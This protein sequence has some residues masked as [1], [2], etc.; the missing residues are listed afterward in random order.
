MRIAVQNPTMPRVNIYLPSDI[1]ELAE[2]WRG[3]RS[4]SEICARAIKDEFD[5][6]EMHRAPPAL[7]KTLRRPSPLEDELIKKFRCV[8]AVTAEAP[9]SEI[10]IREVLGD[11]AA[12]YLDENICDDSAIA[13]AGGRQMWCAV[14]RLSPRRVQT[15]V[16]ALGLHHADPHMLHVHPNALATFMWLLYS[17]RT[18]AHLIG[19]GPQAERWITRPKKNFPAYFVLSSCSELTRESS[20]SRLLGVKTMAGLLK[21]GAVGDYAYA[22]FDRAGNEISS[23][24]TA[25]HFLLGYRDLKEL[26]QRSDARTILCAGGEEKQGVIRLVLNAG[27]ANVLITDSATAV[28]LLNEPAGNGSRKSRRSAK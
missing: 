1:H 26:S 4:L 27:L 16:A 6:L 19:T 23:G 3:D 5:A 10:G 24:T 13:I 17:P 8:D 22:F 18:Q 2:R 21:A 11:L 28:R 14:R 7:L 25:P 9:Q 12:K 15:V 20:L